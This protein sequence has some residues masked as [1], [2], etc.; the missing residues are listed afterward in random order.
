VKRNAEGNVVGDKFR[1]PRGAVRKLASWINSELEG[2][3]RDRKTRAIFEVRPL[4]PDSIKE[5]LRQ[6]LAEFEREGQ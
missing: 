2:L 6:D 4:G 5:A 1:L 3:L